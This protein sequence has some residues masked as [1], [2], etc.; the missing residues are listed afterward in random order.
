MP[1][2]KKNIKRIIQ[3]DDANAMI[4]KA[5][6]EEQRVLVA[7]EYHTGA[8]P[9]E[10][11]ELRRRDFTIVGP[12]LR[13]VLQTKKG[14]DPRLISYDIQATP[15]VPDIVLPWIQ[16]LESADSPI[17][18]FTTTTRIK[19]IIYELSEEKF[20]P[21]NFRH[22]KLTR[23]AMQGATAWELKAFKG[24]KTLRSVEP[25]VNLSPNTLEKFRKMH[26]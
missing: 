1:K 24:A 14:G 11:L 12:D 8:R 6:H 10:L 13:I 7:L 2:Y 5:K 20:C 15:F 22:S 19:Q 16:K 21:Y 3:L 18:S 23:M 17:F 25:Y 26:T 4:A 9:S